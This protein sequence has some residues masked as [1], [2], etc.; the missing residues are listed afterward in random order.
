MGIFSQGLFWHP[1][2][3]V[4]LFVRV[5]FTNSGDETDKCTN[6]YSLVTKMCQ[7]FLAAN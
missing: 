1:P 4:G 7:V 2:S 5:S 3:G 6:Y